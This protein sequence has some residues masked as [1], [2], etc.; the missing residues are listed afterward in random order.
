LCLT[1][2]L[3][4]FTLV[5]LLVVVAIIA[6]LLGILVPAL[7]KARQLA[8][9]T[10]CL[11]N[12]RNMEVAHWMYLNQNDGRFIQVGLPH[13]GAHVDEQRAWINTLREY[14]GNDLLHRSPV[15]HSPYWP[16]DEGGQGLTI[17]GFHRRT[18]YGVNSYLTQY[19]LPD[20]PCEQLNQVPAPAKT[21]HLVIMTFGTGI[22][23]EDEFATADHTHI[24]QWG[25][26]SGWVPTDAA[27]Q[28]AI[29]AHGGPTAHWDSV[30]NWG[31]LD[32][33][34]ETSTLRQVWRSAENNHFNPSLHR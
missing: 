18:S 21:I 14:Y 34:A 17:A 16:R 12:L 28:V 5:E 25:L 10:K 32:G 20:F 8:K 23:D 4:G 13:G 9:R 27:H 11:S 19:G 33:H 26:L 29:D 30:T 2:S 22:P 15:D 3:H 31:Y 7:S 24:D 1:R 6:L